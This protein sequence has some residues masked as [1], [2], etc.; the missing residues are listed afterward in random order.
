MF[1]HEKYDSHV[2]TRPAGLNM[3]VLLKNKNEL[4]IVVTEVKSE[5]SIVRV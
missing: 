3:T 4:A 5:N 2:L 1:F